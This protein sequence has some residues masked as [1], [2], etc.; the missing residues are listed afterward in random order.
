LRQGG[1][2]ALGLHL[3]LTHLVE[4]HVEVVERH[5]FGLEQKSKRLLVLLHLQLARG[6]AVIVFDLGLLQLNA[7]I[8]STHLDFSRALRPVGA[9]V[10]FATT[11][12]SLL[13]FLS[14]QQK[15]TIN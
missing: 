12:I 6:R 10:L 9:N 7:L 3:G 8:S 4:A 14:F 13:F 5:I 11:R 15:K 1:L 2:A